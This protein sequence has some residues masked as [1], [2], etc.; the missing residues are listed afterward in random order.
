MIDG[1]GALAAS[2]LAVAAAAHPVAHHL[3]TG[4]DGHIGQCKVIALGGVGVNDALHLPEKVHVIP[5]VR[6]RRAPGGLPGAVVDGGLLL[7]ADDEGLGVDAHIQL[8]RRARRGLLFD[9]VQVKRSGEGAVFSQV[10]VE[11]GG[12]GGVVAEL[13]VAALGRR[14]GDDVGD[15]D[16][17]HPI[18]GPVLIGVLVLGAGLLLQGDGQ[19]EIV[20]IVAVFVLQDVDR[21]P[22]LH[23]AGLQ[24]SGAGHGI[25]HHEDEPMARLLVLRAP[26]VASV[27]G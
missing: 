7:R 27:R 24:I 11:E 21:D 16:I 26:D 2:E 9:T 22:D 19:L 25:V 13:K 3:L 14:N 20:S 6:R 17:L 8:R 4:G 1:V 15:D 12:K 18:D 10:G 5:R 23:R